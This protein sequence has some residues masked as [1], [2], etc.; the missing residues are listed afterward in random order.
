MV[1]RLSVVGV[2]NSTVYFVIS[3]SSGVV[4]SSGS[5][6]VVGSSGSSGVVG[7]SG[8][9]GSSGSTGLLSPLKTAT[10]SISSVISDFNILSPGE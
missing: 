4:G 6:G 9:S 7:S 10:K 1:S 5:S 8:S 3:G 2:Y